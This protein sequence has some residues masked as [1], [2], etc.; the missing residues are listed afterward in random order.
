MVT[1]AISRRWWSV[2]RTVVLVALDVAL[3]VW[4]AGVILA[5]FTI[6][7]I[8]TSYPARCVNYYGDSISC[9]S[10]DSVV[11]GIAFLALCAVLV[12]AL[13]IQRRLGWVSLSG[14]RRDTARPAT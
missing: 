9:S 3:A 11:E 12:V 2:A 8:Q 4:V 5:R 1:V 7:S 14:P 10:P 6:H 13:W